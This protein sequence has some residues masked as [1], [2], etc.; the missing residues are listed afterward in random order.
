MPEEIGKLSLSLYASPSNVESYFLLL[1]FINLIL[2]IT[3]VGIF[4]GHLS[5]NV[6]ENSKWNI[7]RSGFCGMRSKKVNVFW[8]VF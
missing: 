2:Y 4:S 8:L 5:L 1:L 3:S 7:T 6:S